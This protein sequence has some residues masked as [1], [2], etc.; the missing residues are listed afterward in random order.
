MKRYRVTCKLND[1]TDV[2]LTSED[3][4][5]NNKNEAVELAQQ[6]AVWKERGDGFDVEQL[7]GKIIVSKDG[8]IVRTYSKMTAQ[9]VGTCNFF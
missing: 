9:I 6:Y 1:K 3:I 2:P 5:A 4:V 7:K 8:N